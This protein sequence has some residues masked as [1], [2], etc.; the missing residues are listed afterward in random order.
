MKSYSWR[1]YTGDGKLKT[2][3]SVAADRAEVSAQLRA[4]GY[5]DDDDDLLDD[6]EPEGGSK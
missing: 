1:A 4:D 3:L 6:H 5:Y 2:G